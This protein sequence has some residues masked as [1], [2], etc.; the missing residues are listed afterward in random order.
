MEDINKKLDDL[1]KELVGLP[2]KPTYDDLVTTSRKVQEANQ[3]YKKQ[4]AQNDK[5]FYDALQA[6]KEKS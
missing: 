4:V 6:K 2:E 5:C 3:I 1:V